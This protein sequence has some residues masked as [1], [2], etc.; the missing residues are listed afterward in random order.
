M[1]LDQATVR[2][3]VGALGIALG[4][5]LGVAACGDDP[6]ATTTT[7]TGQ[8]TAEP[9]IDPGDGG[10]YAPQIEPAD[11]VD[12]IDNPYLPFTPG[13]R[14]VY[15]GEAD[16][17]VERIE[18]TVTDEP[19]VV[20]GIPAVVVRDTVTI[21]GAVIEDTYDWYAQDVAGNV[22]Y[23]GEETKEYEDGDVV[24]TDGSWEAGVDGALPGIV[25]QASPAV[26]DAYRQEYYEGEAEDLAEVVR[27]GV[28]ESVPFS[29]YD[30]LLVIREWNPLEP[31]AVEEKYYA[32]GV[33]AVLEIKTRGGDERIELIEYTPGENG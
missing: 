22:W 5:G 27:D 19:R 15:E 11:F 9:V 24:S 21:G 1:T 8:D 30:R 29:D 10:N 4:L 33:G 20:M 32:T 28:P 16:G 31:D 7:S 13:A 26:G 18:V 6:S 25:M 23:L 14:W 2:R 17:E 12:R 3:R